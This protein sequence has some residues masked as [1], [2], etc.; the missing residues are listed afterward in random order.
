M[1]AVRTTG[2]L[3]G[4]ARRR[5]LLFFDLTVD[6]EDPSMSAA[7]DPENVKGE[8]RSFYA[9]GNTARTDVRDGEA[10]VT[11]YWDSDDRGPRYQA[12]GIYPPGW[13]EP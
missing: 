5:D 10:S 13:P 7:P 2:T 3:S 6:T 1:N 9:T 12:Q 4:I 11:V 8:T